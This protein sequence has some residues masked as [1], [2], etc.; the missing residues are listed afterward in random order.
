MVCVLLTLRKALGAVFSG[1]GTNITRCAMVVGGP[2]G[3]MSAV[4]LSTLFVPETWFIEFLQ[5][6]VFVNFA[7]LLLWRLKQFW[8]PM[9]LLKNYKTIILLGS[10]RLHLGTLFEN[11]GEAR[12]QVAI[13][14]RDSATG[15]HVNS[16]LINIQNPRLRKL[17]HREKRGLCVGDWFPLASLDLLI[18]NRRVNTFNFP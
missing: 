7:G 3:Q 4:E 2:L 6:I 15:Y 18:L 8:S 13:L 12:R 16:A 17:M 10:Q 9:L 14:I 11:T 5:D 1:C